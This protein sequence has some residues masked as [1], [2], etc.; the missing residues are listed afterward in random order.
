MCEYVS[1]VWLLLRCM[2]CAAYLGEAQLLGEGYCDPS[3][4]VHPPTVTTK[5][6]SRTAARSAPVATG[7]PPAAPFSVAD[8]R[9]VRLD[10]STVSLRC[11]QQGARLVDTMRIEVSSEQVSLS[12]MVVLS[13]IALRD[14]TQKYSL[15]CTAYVIYW[16]I[17]M[18]CMYT[19]L[20]YNVHK[21]L[22]YTVLYDMTYIV[23]YIFLACRCY[24][25]A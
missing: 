12:S 11:Y 9:D 10:P 20:H 2:R 23:P 22:Y 3:C 21:H 18:N 25:P 5:S 16:F 15:L 4:E 17:I 8:L 19:T 14:T 13:S 24:R 6:S 7:T 1:F